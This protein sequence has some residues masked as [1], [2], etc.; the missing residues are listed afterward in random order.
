[1]PLVTVIVLLAGVLVL[2]V[3]NV[4]LNTKLELL[5]NISKVEICL[6]A[7]V[8]I[9]GLAIKNNVSPLFAE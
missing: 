2:L 5:P 6:I 1:M 7:Q 4:P 8:L 3:T 9:V